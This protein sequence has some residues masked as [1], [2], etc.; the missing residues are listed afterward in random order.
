MFE[1]FKILFP[2]LKNGGIYVV[3]DTQTSYWKDYGGNSKDLNDENTIYYFFKSL[4]DSLNHNEF[5]IEEHEKNYY[6]RYIISMHF[7]H[8]MIFI[9]K[10]VN[11]EPSNI[12]VNNKLK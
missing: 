10:G 7:Y 8:N 2:K 6:D 4:I 9:Y 3:E 1:S 12:V 5:I 11:N